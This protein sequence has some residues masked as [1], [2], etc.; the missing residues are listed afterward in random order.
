MKKVI[1]S[2]LLIV[3]ASAHAQDRFNVIRIFTSAGILVYSGCDI[4]IQS[5][6]MT[7]SCESLEIQRLVIGPTLS[8]HQMNVSVVV[9][10][11]MISFRKVRLVSTS[12][13]SRSATFDFDLRDNPKEK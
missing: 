8:D 1:L 10:N 4:G 3:F 13:D 5:L 9:D 2:I 11:K 6:N 7:A 12:I